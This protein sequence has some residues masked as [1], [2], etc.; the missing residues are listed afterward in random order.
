M[1]YYINIAKK[2][3][4]GPHNVSYKLIVK[5][6]KSLQKELS[7]RIFILQSLIKEF[8]SDN[9]LSRLQNYYYINKVESQQF[10]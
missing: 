3:G 4:R 1:D 5:K 9:I 7:E 8:L 10:L 6:K 2:S